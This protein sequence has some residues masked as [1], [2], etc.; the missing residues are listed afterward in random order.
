MTESMVQQLTKLINDVGL[1]VAIIVFFLAKDWIQGSTNAKL[2]TQLMDK[3]TN[4]QQNSLDT[5]RSTNLVLGKMSDNM[6]AIKTKLGT[7]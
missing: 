2:I 1:P 3:F 4:F 6:I 7:E 5:Q